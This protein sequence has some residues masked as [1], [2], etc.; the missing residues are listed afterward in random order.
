[1]IYNFR[2]IAIAV[3][4]WFIYIKRKYKKSL[5]R[6]Q[7]SDNNPVRTYS[8]NFKII[9]SFIYSNQDYYIYIYL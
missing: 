9:Q 6:N 5:T 4:N 8:N 1:M 3:K 7:K 2:F